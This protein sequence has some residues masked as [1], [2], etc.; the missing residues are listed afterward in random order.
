MVAREQPGAS[1]LCVTLGP[2]CRSLIQRKL[3]DGMVD[4]LGLDPGPTDYETAGNGRFG[5]SV[6]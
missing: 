1:H 6:D 2:R 5:G 4:A 3:V